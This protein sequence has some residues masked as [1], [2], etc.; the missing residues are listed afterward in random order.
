MNRTKRML[1]FGGAVAAVTGLAVLASLAA[2]T[3]TL[4]A[5][6][7]ADAGSFQLTRSV[8]GYPVTLTT[9]ASTYTVQS[10]ATG[11]TCVAVGADIT[12]AG[13][14]WFRNIGTATVTIAVSG[15]DCL[16]LLTNDFALVRLVSTNVTAK[17][18]AGSSSGQLESWINV[19]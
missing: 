15:T 12:T 11:A 17:A 7:R 6:V 10:I 2:D 14:C 4:A 16:K 5:S 1:V 9:R 19:E 18:T 3:L 13:Y 8:A